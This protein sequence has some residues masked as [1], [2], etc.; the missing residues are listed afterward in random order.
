MCLT[1]LIFVINW[2]V[3]RWWCAIWW[4]LGCFKVMMCLVVENLIDWCY[5]DEILVCYNLVC[6]N[7]L[8]I[9]LLLVLNRQIDCMCRKI[10]LELADNL[11]LPSILSLICLPCAKLLA[12]FVLGKYSPGPISRPREIRRILRSWSQETTEGGPRGHM[13]MK[14]GQWVWIALVLNGWLNKTYL[15]TQ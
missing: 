7:L 9:Y 11:D 13:R 4:N 14:G 6:L 10:W 12:Q 2:A 8:I 3:L 5:W 15:Q 1:N